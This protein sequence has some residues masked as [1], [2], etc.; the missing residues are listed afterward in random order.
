MSGDVVPVLRDVLSVAR[1][2]TPEGDDALWVVADLLEPVDPNTARPD[3]VLADAALLLFGEV[4]FG[5]TNKA[6]LWLRYAQRVTADVLGPSDSLTCWA[7]T[8]AGRLFEQLGRHEEAASAWAAAATAHAANGQWREADES[9]VRQAKYLYGIGQCADAVAIVRQVWERWKVEQ[10][11]A[12]VG[13]NA[14]ILYAEML[15]FC[16]R[17]AEARVMWSELVDRF[18]KERWFNQ[19]WVNWVMEYYKGPVSAPAH[20]QVCAFR[21]RRTT[22]DGNAVDGRSVADQR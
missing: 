5:P 19:E 22:R 1:Q 4:G 3:V 8:A 9:R 10:F 18:G 12:A 21:T 6:L 17:R 15:R 20:W 14:L 16:F 11:G 2:E 13:A 7:N